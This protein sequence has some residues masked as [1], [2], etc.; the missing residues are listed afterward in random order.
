[1]PFSFSTEW[2]LSFGGGGKE[3]KKCVVLEGWVEEC[4][5]SKLIKIWRLRGQVRIVIS[6]ATI[7]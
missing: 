5:S 2:N 1:M 7:Q 3:Q 6:I 4:H